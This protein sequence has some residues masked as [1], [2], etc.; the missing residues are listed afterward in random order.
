M[1]DIDPLRRKTHSTSRPEN[2]LIEKLGLQAALRSHLLER[3]VTEAVKEEM[4]LT[5]IQMM[6]EQFSRCDPRAGPTRPLEAWRCA[7]TG[8]SNTSAFQV[9]SGMFQK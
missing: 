2:M 7:Q 5:E 3:P 8:G 1:L 4:A 6:G 9:V